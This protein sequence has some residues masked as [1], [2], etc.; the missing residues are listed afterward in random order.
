MLMYRLSKRGQQLCN[1]PYL[2]VLVPKT[3]NYEIRKT[4]QI[5]FLE[6]YT[7]EGQEKVVAT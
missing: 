3:F 1:D 7:D 5:A 6:R 2:E 4:S